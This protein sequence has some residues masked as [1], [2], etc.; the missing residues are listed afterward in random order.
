V[1]TEPLRA[2]HHLDQ[3]ALLPAPGGWT[4]VGDL[5]SPDGYSAQEVTEQV[6]AAASEHAAACRALPAPTHRPSR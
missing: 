1:T 5:V 4:T 6:R 2:D 3:V